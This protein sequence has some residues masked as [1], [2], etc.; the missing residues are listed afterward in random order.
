[1]TTWRELGYVPDSD[2][3]DSDA[4]LSTQ[5]DEFAPPVLPEAVSSESLENE[6]KQNGDEQTSTRA[7]E[8]SNTDP[9]K[10][11][12]QSEPLPVR[13]DGFMD[14]DVAS[15]HN[16]SGKEDQAPPPAQKEAEKANIQYADLMDIDNLP[17]TTTQPEKTVGK[18]TS[19]VDS[20]DLSNIP[21][22]DLSNLPD[23]DDDENA[24]VDL[25]V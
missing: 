7:V 4:E 10:Q 18:H 20:I 8:E 15:Q 14:I 3:E 23:E 22:V 13:D 11:S 25:Q 12:T 16:G 21:I 17:G 24:G 9:T 19:A 1:M 5:E 6:I 2:G